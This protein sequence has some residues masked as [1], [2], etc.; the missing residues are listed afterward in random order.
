MRKIL[1]INLVSVFL[2]IAGPPAFALYEYKVDQKLPPEGQFESE[3]SAKFT[4][5][6]T[7][8]IYGW[9]EIIRT[10]VHIAQDPRR[11]PIFSSIVGFPY[12]ILRFAGRTLVGI[13]EVVSFAAPQ[14]PIFAPIEGDVL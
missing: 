4:R 13:Y 5:G 7:N 2:L 6:V 10:P 9:T 11:G 3:I 14:P 1:W 8:I 12:G